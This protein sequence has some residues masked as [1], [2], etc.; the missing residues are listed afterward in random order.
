MAPFE[1][2]WPDT[3]GNPSSSGAQNGTRY[4]FFQHKKLLLIEHDGK[5]QK[6]RTGEHRITGVSQVSG[7]GALTFTTEHGPISLED[8]E[9]AQ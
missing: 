1:Q 7:R 5:L 2:W 3:L 9:K 6:F 8:F 4:A